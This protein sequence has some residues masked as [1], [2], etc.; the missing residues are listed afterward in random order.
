[1]PQVKLSNVL[2]TVDMDAHLELRTLR[3]AH[4]AVQ[5][6]IARQ[7]RDMEKLKEEREE[8]LRATERLQNDRDATALVFEVKPR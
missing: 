1:M 3:D 5:E 6:K 8:A 7:E 2:E 4:E